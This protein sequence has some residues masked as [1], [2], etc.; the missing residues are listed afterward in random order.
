MALMLDPDTI[1]NPNDTS[2]LTEGNTSMNLAKTIVKG[3]RVNLAKDF[4]AQVTK[5]A[6]GLDW[7]P[8]AGMTADCDISTISVDA[9]D[10]PIGF[11]DESLCFYANPNL[12][13]IK[14]YGDN[15]TGTDSESNTPTGSDEQIDIDLLAQNENTRAIYAIATTH[16]EIP[17]TQ[18]G[19]AGTPG[20][21]QMFGRVAAPVLTVYN[22][23]DPANPVPLLQIELDEE[24][25][26]ATAV[27]CAKFYKNK[28]DEW[29]FTAMGD[30]VG[31]HAFG[32]QATV[33]KFGVTER[34]Q[35]Q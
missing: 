14:S 8:K 25:S 2:Q 3:E 33:D 16:S 5:Y 34:P 9:D 31:T 30:Q 27:E 26:V 28:N 17:S 23:T 12:A 7:N 4:G 6:I 22:N 19:V 24:H 10:K 32:L 18:E 13:G 15:K 20:E 29:C 21:P 35:A 1:N 11:A